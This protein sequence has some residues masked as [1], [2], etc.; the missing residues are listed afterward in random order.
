LS[1]LEISSE[2]EQ[3]ALETVVVGLVDPWGLAFLPDG[4]MLVTERKGQLR[5][6]EHGA[7]LPEP[8]A[9]VPLVWA[10]G[11]GGLLDVAVDPKYAENGWVYLSFSD[12]GGGDR[13]TTAVARGR[14]VS[15]RWTDQQVL[16]RPPVESY[17]QSMVHFGSRMAFD[18]EGQLFVSIGDRGFSDDAQDLWSSNGKIHRITESGKQLWDE[19]FGSGALLTVWSYGH[20]NP[21]GLAFDRRTGQLWETEQGPRGGDELNRIE[22]GGNYGWPL[23]S[24]GMSYDGKRAS[25][26]TEL[27]G[28]IPPVHQWTPSIT[29]SSM[30]FYTGVVFPRWTNNLFVTCLSPQ[31]LRRLE[32]NDS[33][34]QHEEILLRGV[35]RARD[36]VEGPDG[37]I[38]VVLNQPDRVARIVP[39]HP[40]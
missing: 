30:S 38:Y 2:L 27:E 40:R 20:R 10:K 3:F 34:V 8:I 26:R 7:L 21:Q 24:Y 28:T 15:G 17:R 29:V 13:A 25:V 33:H 35:G 39:R 16:L 18:N 19:P 4:R 11:Q 6:V 5:V 14:L 37:N 36:V 31:Q 23:V 22:R 1:R 9:G 32:I 12:D